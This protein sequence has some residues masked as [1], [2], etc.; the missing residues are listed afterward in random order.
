MSQR[1]AE[2]SALEEE[3]THPEQWQSQDLILGLLTPSPSPELFLFT[4]PPIDTHALSNLGLW[5]TQLLS[6]A[7]ILAPGRSEHPRMPQECPNTALPLATQC[8]AWE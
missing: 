5:I 7:I 2:L 8:R 4:L 3:V 6:S 1:G